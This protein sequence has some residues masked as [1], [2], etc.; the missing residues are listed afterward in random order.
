MGALAVGEGGVAW[1]RNYAGKLRFVNCSTSADPFGRSM[2]ARGGFV[3]VE[4]G[5]VEIIGCNLTASPATGG[6]AYVALSYIGLTM[7]DCHVSGEGVSSGGGVFFRNGVLQRWDQSGGGAFMLEHARMN[8]TTSTFE[9]FRTEGEGGGLVTALQGSHVSFTD[10]VLFNNTATNSNGGV[11]LMAS[12]S[13]LSFTGCEIRNN[14]ARV[15]GGVVMSDG[16]L[17]FERCTVSS[18]TALSGGGA[19]VHAGAGTLT[20]RGCTFDHNEGLRSYSTGGALLVRKSILQIDD[21]RFVSNQAP[22]G[23]AISLN[24]GPSGSNRLSLGSI[25]NTRFENNR[26]VVLNGVMSPSKTVG[27]AIFALLDQGSITFNNVT[28]IRNHADG[29]GFLVISRGHFTMNDCTFIRNEADEGGVALIGEIPELLTEY[30]ILY[31]IP[32]ATNPDPPVVEFHDCSFTENW[33]H[34]H[35]GV[36]S[37]GNMK[38]RVTGSTFVDNSVANAGL[39]GLVMFYNDGEVDIA[40]TTITRGYAGEGS[41]AWI[42]ARCSLRLDGVKVSGVGALSGPCLRIS[43]F[44]A[45]LT[46][47]QC[48]FENI[49]C[50]GGLIRAAEGK[51][52]M[53]EMSNS[54]FRNIQA[55]TTSWLM[56]AE[57][58]VSVRFS[59]CSFYTSNCSSSSSSSFYFEDKEARGYLSHSSFDPVGV[60]AT[61]FVAAGTLRVEDMQLDLGTRGDPSPV[62]D[63]IGPDALIEFHR[64]RVRFLE[65]GRTNMTTSPRSCF[66]WVR[67]GSFMFNETT[68]EDLAGSG[69]CIA[70]LEGGGVL[71]VERNVNVIRDGSFVVHLPSDQWFYVPWAWV[72]KLHGTDGLVRLWEDSFSLRPSGD[73]AANK[74]DGTPRKPLTKKEGRP[75]KWTKEEESTWVCP[76]GSQRMTV[77]ANYPDE[78][79]I[80]PATEYSTLFDSQTCFTCPSRGAICRHGLVGAEKGWWPLR[81]STGEIKLYRCK[82]ERCDEAAPELNWH[83]ETG[84]HPVGEC[85]NHHAGTLCGGCESGF[86]QWAGTCVKCTKAHAGIIFAI[87]MLMWVYVIFQ[88]WQAQGRGG[89]MK[90]IMYFG[91]AATLMAT[92]RLASQVTDLFLLEGDFVAASASV[93]PF[94]QDEYTRFLTRVLTPFVLQLLLGATFFIVEMLVRFT[95]AAGAVA[96]AG[97]DPPKYKTYVTRDAFVRTSLVILVYSY[98]IVTW[99]ALGFFNCIHVGD[100]Q[101]VAEAPDIRCGAHPWSAWA[102]LYGTLFLVAVLGGPA[103]LA[104]Y[105]WKQKHLRQ[106]YHPNVVAWFGGLFEDYKEDFYWW[107]VLFLLRRLVL[108]ATAAIAAQIDPGDEHGTRPWALMLVSLIF[109]VHHLSSLPFR[110]PN[111]NRLETASLFTLVLLASL[112]GSRLSDTAEGTTAGLFLALFFLPLAYAL[113]LFVRHMRLQ[114][115]ASYSP[116]G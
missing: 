7:R 13:T 41:I 86:S 67:T 71:D 42:S 64:G 48:T 27:G 45:S 96:P 115:K 114:L 25:N 26:A 11:A 43:D 3:G 59:H 112:G 51:D 75:W 83:D 102:V 98:V 105:L 1:L 31:R 106:L 70:Q 111:Q 14:S 40:R 91:Q 5:S 108:V 72:E 9:N 58:A 99:T 104:W 47:D 107:E 85:A 80:C 22:R 90:T 77:A 52:H 12:D 33:A 95:G 97:G 109:A 100:H 74:P 66:I 87:L 94:P 103:L 36:M 10:C 46:A 101:V 18:N 61:I 38:A 30:A 6:I 89:S 17:S 20:I 49:T 92:P 56:S 39:G 44:Q 53:V 93:C 116:L 79:S 88:H 81:V 37:V 28:A 76:P 8:V 82:Y 35:G 29:G 23:G 73:T 2:A 78:C 15:E 60:N 32:F 54:T 62:F 65:T 84:L 57:A 24:G 69:E 16:P 110:D 113:G 50:R 21:T 19:V 55:V 4:S 34:V 68:F 63:V